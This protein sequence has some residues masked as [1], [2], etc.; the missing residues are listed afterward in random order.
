MRAIEVIDATHIGGQ[1]RFVNHSCDPN[2]VFEK[3]NV[4][5]FERCGVFTM[6]EVH[7]GEG[8]VVDCQI[9]YADREV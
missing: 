9:H 2:Y 3:W 8:F 6:R 1:M 5:G 4:R 7:T